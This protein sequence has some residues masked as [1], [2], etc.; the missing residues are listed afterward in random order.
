MQS[1]THPRLRLSAAHMEAKSRA[2]KHLPRLYAGY[3]KHLAQL[4]QD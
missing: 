1:K 2:C 4:L 3:S